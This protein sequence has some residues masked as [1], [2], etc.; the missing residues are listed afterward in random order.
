M[1][2]QSVNEGG[3]FSKML[4]QLSSDPSSMQ[5]M[6]G[7]MEKMDGIRKN[8]GQLRE[9]GS[10]GGGLVSVTMDGNN[11]VVSFDISQAFI[12][13]SEGDEENDDSEG[14]SGSFL[15]RKQML[16]KLLVEACADAKKK[17]ETAVILTMRNFMDLD[18]SLKDVLHAIPEKM[19]R[20]V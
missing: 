6:N 10:A 11:N 20:N 18:D 17:I 15:E 16:E 14:G 9:T 4:K 7:F 1:S 19:R 2:N 13:L 3:G 5:E 12:G 8:M